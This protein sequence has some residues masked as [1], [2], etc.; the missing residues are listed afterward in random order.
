MNKKQIAAEIFRLRFSQ[1][2]IND[3]IKQGKFKIPI[4]LAMGHE[5]I[6]VAVSAV[7]RGQDK[8]IL[9]HRNLAYHLARSHSLK[10]I[11]DEYLL[12]PTGL[13]RG[14]S[15]SMNLADLKRGIV[16]T[17]SI[18]GNNFPV[19]VG[20]AM[21]EKILSRRGLTIVLGGDGSIEEGAFYE[22]LTLAKTLGLSIMFIIENNGWSLATKISERRCPI[23]LA[24]LT[25]AVRIKY[26]KLVGNDPDQY[27]ANLKRLRRYSLLK[28][29][30]V[31]VEVQLVTLGDW[32][33]PATPQQPQGRFINYHSGPAPDISFDSS[34]I[35]KCNSSDPVFLVSQQLTESNISSIR[36]EVT[37][38]LNL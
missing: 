13:N 12:K 23:D 18:L 7:M 32:R 31:C 19:A 16:Y 1:M 22:S 37:K 33:G 6:A 28:Q 29:E 34:P 8:L 15:G 14:R 10:P 3:G 26:A 9:S 11:V 2:A 21:A 36:R 5:T 25:G 27:V 24:K 30:P 38:N 35:I 20:V 17:S 4:H